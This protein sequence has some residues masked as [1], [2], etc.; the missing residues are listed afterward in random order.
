MRLTNITV[1]WMLCAAMVM[2]AF[3]Q[4]APESDEETQQVAAEEETA[5]P[6]LKFAT[7]TV[8][9]PNKVATLHLGEKYHYLAPAEASQLL[10]MWGNPPDET[11]QGAIFPADV[12]PLSEKGWAVFLT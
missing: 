12:N 8:T 3:A 9:L 2:P 11:T 5:L 7:G 6:E 4:D 10:Q 1:A